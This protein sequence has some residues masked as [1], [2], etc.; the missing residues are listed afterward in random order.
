MP[1][2]ITK[3]WLQIR[4]QQLLLIYFRRILMCLWIHQGNKMQNYDL[5]LIKTWCF[6]SLCTEWTLRFCSIN[7][8]VTVHEVYCAVSFSIQD[9][10]L[11]W[12]P[13]EWRNGPSVS[14]VKRFCFA[15]QFL[16]ISNENHHI[17]YIVP[18]FLT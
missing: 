13:D 3:C 9:R 4:W 5:Y 2:G 16:S 10:Q 15:F 17:T 7:V 11:S 8:A 1:L 18:S 6:V 14:T 12:L